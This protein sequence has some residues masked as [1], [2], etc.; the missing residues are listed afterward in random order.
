MTI[1]S[2][3]LMQYIVQSSQKE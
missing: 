3:D 1:M 2:G